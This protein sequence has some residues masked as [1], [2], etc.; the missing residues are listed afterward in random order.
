MAARAWVRGVATGRGWRSRGEKAGAYR[1]YEPKRIGATRPARS[2]AARSIGTLPGGD[3]GLM[4]EPPTAPT[5]AAAP[6]RVLSVTKST[7]T[8]KRATVT[9][10][11]ALERR[12]SRDESPRSSSPP[13]SWRAT[14]VAAPPLTPGNQ[15]TVA[16]ATHPETAPRTRR[17]RGGRKSP[18]PWGGSRVVPDRLRSS[19]GSPK[20]PTKSGRRAACDVST[21]SR[22]APAHRP[23]APS[24]TEPRAPARAKRESARRRWRAVDRRSV[25]R[26][27]PPTG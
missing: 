26:R 12:N 23:R 6:L 17:Q 4:D 1:Y 10:T 16:P 15:A 25:P 7:T 24:T 20:S 2:V 19:V 13:A 3:Q 18:A 14:I 8:E 27:N 11:A 9:F 5:A 21:G 22:D